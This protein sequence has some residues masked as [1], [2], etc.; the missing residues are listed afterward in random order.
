MNHSK[1]I[2]RDD[3]LRINQERWFT[4]N[5]SGEMIHSISNRRDES[6]KMD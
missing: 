3:S 2:R 4:Q 6:I 1:W 5:G